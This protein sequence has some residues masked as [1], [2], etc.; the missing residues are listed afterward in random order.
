MK[1][2][3]MATSFLA[4]GLLA[5]T[6]S[7]Q[8]ADY[9]FDKKGAH[10]FVQFRVQHLGYSW[11]YGRFNDFD[12]TF[13]YDAAEP[14]KAKVSVK[15]DT[16]SVDTNHAERDKHLRGDDF[17]DVDKFPEA[18][19]EST[20]FDG[21]TLKGDLTLHGVTKPVSIAVEKIGEGEDPWGGYRAGF[22]GRTTFKMADFGIE[23]N[24]GPKSADVE[25]ILSVEGIRLKG[26]VKK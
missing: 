4:L 17:L 9:A 3:T 20:S 24:L 16:S 12:G 10:Q 21:K 15:I 2:K 23:K 14:E 18:T 22:E 1:L 19:F 13:S 5:G 7:A 8:A 6:L 25:M 26:D 11:L